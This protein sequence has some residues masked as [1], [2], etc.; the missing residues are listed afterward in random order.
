MTLLQMFKFPKGNDEEDICVLD[1]RPSSGLVGSASLACGLMPYV[2]VPSLNP[3]ITISQ[4]PEVYTLASVACLHEG[5][6]TRFLRSMKARRTTVRRQKARPSLNTDRLIGESDSEEE[7]EEE[8]NS[9]S[10]EMEKEREVDRRPRLKERRSRERPPAIEISDQE[11][12]RADKSFEEELEA[13]QHKQGK[14]KQAT[15]HH[16]SAIQH[17]A[18]EEV[19]GKKKHGGTDQTSPPPRKRRR[20]GK[21]D[22]PAKHQTKKK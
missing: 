20:T 4:V 17:K 1:F 22:K 21:T 10:E 12:I 13:S 2:C 16:H 9:G 18:R 7:E 14:Q 8:S 6:I 15:K 3:I 5:Y 11:S 19:E